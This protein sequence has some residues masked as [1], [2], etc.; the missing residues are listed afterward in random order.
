MTNTNTQHCEIPKQA[1]STPLKQLTS[2]DYT[3]ETAM[4]EN[5]I[6]KTLGRN[7]QNDKGGRGLENSNPL[8]VQQTNTSSKAI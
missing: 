7:K 8:P 5:E 2:M 6:K 4:I 1:A 3:E